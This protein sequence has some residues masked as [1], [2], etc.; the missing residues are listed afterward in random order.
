MNCTEKNKSYL[1]L[2]ITSF[3]L[4]ISIYYILDSVNDYVI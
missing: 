2:L 3:G 4:V 1:I